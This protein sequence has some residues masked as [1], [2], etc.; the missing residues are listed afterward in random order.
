MILLLKKDIA[1]NLPIHSMKEQKKD[2][3]KK[4]ENSAR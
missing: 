3:E 2:I 4:V 1:L